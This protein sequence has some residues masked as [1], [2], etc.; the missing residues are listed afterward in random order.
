MH[1]LVYPVS[2]RSLFHTAIG[3]Q[4]H[5]IDDIASQTNSR[6]SGFVK[7]IRNKIPQRFPD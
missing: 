3:Y 4:R 6:Q 7:D 2:S 5:K 1:R